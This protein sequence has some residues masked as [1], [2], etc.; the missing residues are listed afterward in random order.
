MSK[1][2]L[3]KFKEIATFIPKGRILPNWVVKIVQGNKRQKHKFKSN[4]C[5]VLTRGNDMWIVPQF[6]GQ[7]SVHIEGAKN[8]VA[9]FHPYRKAEIANLFAPLRYEQLINLLPEE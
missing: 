8:L 5:Y 3:A 1:M 2:T 4:G 9:T 6:D 7:H